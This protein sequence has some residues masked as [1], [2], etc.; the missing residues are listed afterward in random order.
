[1]AI[2][3]HLRLDRIHVMTKACFRPGITSSTN[4]QRDVFPLL[5]VVGFSVWYFSIKRPYALSISDNT[6]SQHMTQNNTITTLPIRI[7]ATMHLS[8][9]GSFSNT[10][11]LVLWSCQ[12]LLSQSINCLLLLEALTLSSSSSICLAITS[13]IGFPLE[14]I[15]VFNHWLR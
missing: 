5:T 1:M 12:P 8:L 9:R 4:L 6:Q 15:W 3:L 13:T 7:L 11:C 2:F 14:P 10:Y